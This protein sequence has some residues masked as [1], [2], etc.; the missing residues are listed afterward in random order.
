MTVKSMRDFD[1]Y[2]TRRMFGFQ[3]FLDYYNSISSVKMLKDVN[4]PLL[5]MHSRDDP[6]L[7]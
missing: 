5:C 2:L 7:Q 3:N 4:I 6:F 1:E